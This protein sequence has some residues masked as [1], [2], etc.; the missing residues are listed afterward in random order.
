MF[1]GRRTESV[2]DKEIIKS[3][4]RKYIIHIRAARPVRA[5]VA[6][7][8]NSLQCAVASLRVHVYMYVD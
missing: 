8:V 6:T 3:T 4:D 1:V 2:E 7:H 5:L